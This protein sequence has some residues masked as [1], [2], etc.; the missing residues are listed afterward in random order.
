MRTLIKQDFD[1]AFERVDVIAGPTAPHTAFK[2][3]ENVNDPLSMYLADIYTI[4]CNLAGLP[5]L[6]VPCGKDEQGLPM[7]LQLI[8]KHFDE[9]T[10]FQ[11]ARGFE[12][13]R[14]AFSLPKW[15]EAK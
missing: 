14:G 5:G 4:S 11:I 7:G 10:L 2:L 8:G 1:Q 15:S 6:S 12:L 3:G 13:A 9:N